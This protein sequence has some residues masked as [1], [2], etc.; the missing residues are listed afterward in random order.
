MRFH[1]HLLVESTPEEN[2]KFVGFNLRRIKQLRFTQPEGEFAPAL[3]E[4]L[5]KFFKLKT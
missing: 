1:L 5:E 4:N 2:D 3:K